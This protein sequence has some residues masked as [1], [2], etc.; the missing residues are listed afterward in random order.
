[1]AARASRLVRDIM[2][3][4]LAVLHEEDNL[5]I[6]DN[7]IK[8]FAF[9]HLPV[10]DDGKIVGLI[11]E[12]DLLRAS[13]STLDEEHALRDHC[14]KR[15]FF[16]REIMTT[17]VVTVRPETTLLEAAR[18]LGAQR[19]GCLPVTESDGTLVGIVTRGDFL[20]LATS[21]LEQAEA[22]RLEEV[23][24]AALHRPH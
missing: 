1:M 11:S 19:I 8:T 18:I 3:R 12:R 6:A 17:D 20:E 2:K 5:E 21:F 23:R 22:S 7:G 16:V 9:R 24:D 14:V 10:V 13:V 4:N 15:F